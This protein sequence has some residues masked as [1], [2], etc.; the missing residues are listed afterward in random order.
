MIDLNCY[1][2]HF[3]FRQL[4][5]NTADALLKWMDEKG[6]RTGHGLQRGRH[7]L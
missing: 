6:H 4:R 2:G 3:A 7:N 5:Y 1:L